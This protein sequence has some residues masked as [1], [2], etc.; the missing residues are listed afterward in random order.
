MENNIESDLIELLKIPPC[1][2]EVGDIVMVDQSKVD[3]HVLKL[4]GR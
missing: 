2:V 1:T 3:K 4:E